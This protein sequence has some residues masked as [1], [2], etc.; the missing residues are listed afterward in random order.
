MK[1]KVKIFGY[2]SL[3]CEESLLRTAPCAVDIIP[4]KLFGFFRIFNAKCS[5]FCEVN[6]KNVAAL[7]IEKSEYNQYLNGICFEVN[8]E[9]LDSL[10]QREQGYELIKIDLVD[11]N[12]NQFTAFTFRYPHFEAEFEYLFNSKPQKDYL[13]LC[14]QGAQSF[15]EQ[16][17]REFLET[18]F[19]GEKNLNF[20]KKELDL[21]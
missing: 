10:I 3:L 17:L 19:I 6:G 9:D 15:G 18:T 7:N 14:Y 13:N 12:N 5:R 8:Q 4:C 2:G 21:E 16:F 1:K 20:F 11:Y